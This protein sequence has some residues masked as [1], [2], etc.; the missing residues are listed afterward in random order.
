MNQR[1][2]EHA[3]AFGLQQAAPPPDKE[4]EILVATADGKGVPMRRPLEEQ[5]RRGPR[6]VK[7]EK[8]NKKQMAYVGAVYT[9]DRFRRTADEVLDEIARRE[10]ATARPVPQHKQLW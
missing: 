3:E 2:A 10:R 4:G 7:G 9:I 1:M 6:R 5:V 8:A